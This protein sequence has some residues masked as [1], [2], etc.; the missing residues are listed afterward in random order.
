MSRLSVRLLSFGAVFAAGAVLLLAQPDIS[1]VWVLKIPRGDG[2]FRKT[3]YELKQDGQTVTMAT[4]GA[5]RGPVAPAPPAQPPAG[6]PP[7]AGRGGGR[8][9]A[10]PMTATFAGGKIRF[11]MGGRG[12]F[13]QQKQPAAPTVYE[14]PLEGGK[15][16]LAITGGGGG[17]GRGGPAPTTAVL[18]RSTREAFDLPRLPLPEFHT[19]KSNGLA[20]TP[21]MGWNSWNLFRGRVD[22]KLVREIADAMI[23]SGMKK[24]GY[25]YV[26]IDDTWEG[27]S[28]D[29]QGNMTTNT[30]F[31]DMKALADYVHSKGLKIGIY[32][33]PG[34]TTCQ[35]YEGSY[36]HEA[37]DAKTFAQWGIDYLKYDW[38]GA[39]RVYTDEDMHAAYQKMGD[40]LLKAGRPIVYSLCQYG[41]AKVWEWGPSVGGNLWRTTGDIGDRWQSMENLGFGPSIPGGIRQ[42]NQPAPPN[43]TQLDIAKASNVG[44]WNDPDMLE[45]GN[46]GMTA[47]EYRTHFALWC[48]LRA[49]LLAGNDIR[50]M[51]QETKD[52]LLNTEVIAIDQDAAALPAK[53][54]S[55]EGTSD[56]IVRP[57]KDKSTAVALFNRGDQATTISVTWN[58][59]GLGGKKL[60]GRDLWKHEAVELSGDR[61]STSV[62]SHGVVLLKVSAQ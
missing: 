28:R 9:P 16:V 3:F 52:I 23:T 7:A 56:V 14:G 49:P 48:M 18:E 33:S 53:L 26:N 45:V 44:H 6:A 54:A 39:S 5:G 31:P 10:M 41:R 25:I 24:A 13:G 12:G 55:R 11:E 42:P 8:G 32:S 47:D 62:P 35:Q 34:P 43:L 30:K 46:G 27:E 36:G 58:A 4:M 60:R 51:T 22:D 17:G 59:I 2:T 19:V 37:Q 29:A 20:K 61:Y 40:A 15:F 21:P 38:C 50:T 57:L 1:G